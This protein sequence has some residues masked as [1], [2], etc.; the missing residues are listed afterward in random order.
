MDKDRSAVVDVRADAMFLPF[1]DGSVVSIEADQLLEHFDGAHARIVLWECNRVLAANGTLV[2]E[3]PDI[4]KAFKRLSSSD[5]RRHDAELQWIYGIDSPGLGHKTGFTKASLRS[6]LKESSFGQIAFEAPRT[7]TYEPGLRATC[8]KREPE[9]GLDAAIA[10]TINSLALDRQFD[11]SFVLI[12]LREELAR[13]SRS[14]IEAD[15]RFFSRACILNPQVALALQS[16]IWHGTPNEPD[17][18]QTEVMKSLRQQRL[19]E[20]A[21]TLWKKSVK[22]RGDRKEFEEFSERLSRDVRTCLDDGKVQEA[23]GYVLSLE[24]SPTKLMSYALIACEGQR[25]TGLGMKLFA[26]KD[27]DRAEELFEDAIAANPQDF[28]AAWNFARLLASAEG[29]AGLAKELY[30]SAIDAAPKRQRTV[31]KQ[32]LE[33]YERSG[34]APKVPFSEF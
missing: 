14:S 24:P 7:H 6:I 26:S 16:A 30:E 13:L 33:E 32:E 19:H 17:G 21:F 27:Y 25:M 15:S 28:M 20:K 31:I 2:I 29:R 18:V 4:E 23:L 12:P 22:L 34:S 10:R 3:T 5:S 11:D 1:R 8:A 9:H